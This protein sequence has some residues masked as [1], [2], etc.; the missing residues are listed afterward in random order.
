MSSSYSF[1]VRESHLDTFGH[2]NN[3]TYLSLF[4]EARWEMITQRGFGLKEIKERKLGPVILACEVKFSREV[5]LREQATITTELL[6]YRGKIGR[7]TQKMLKSNGEVACEA[8]FT[9]GLFDLKERKLI[10]P[11][12]EWKMA[13]GLV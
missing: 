8:T 11:T 3:A 2:M 1:V 5:L 12:P 6:D 13:V 4:E 7:L 9:F 10:E